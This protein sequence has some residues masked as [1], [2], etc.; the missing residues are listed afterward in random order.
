[1][2]NQEVIDA[3]LQ[4]KLDSWDWLKRSSEKAVDDA[5]A[6]MTPPP[7]FG[8]MKPW[9]H[10]KVCFLILQELKRFMLFLD[11]G[12]GKTGTTLQIIRYRKQCGEKPKCIVF[13]PYITAVNTWLDE[14]VKFAPDLEVV[15][16][17]GS[18]LQNRETLKGDGDVFVACY[19][20][21]VAMVTET[22][23]DKRKR[24]HKNKWKTSAQQ[25]RSYFEGFDMIVM[26]EI[27]KCRDVGSLTYRMCRAI[28]AQ[29]EWAIGLTGTPFGKDLADLWPQFYLVDFGE[30][31]G[32]TFGLFREAF[33]TNKAGY[34][35]GQ[36][37]KFRKKMMGQLKAFVRHRSIRYTLDEFIDMPELDPVKRFV[38]PPEGAEGYIEAAINSLNG[39]AK[40]RGKGTYQVIE[41][42][43]LQLRQL[44]SGF[45]TLRG[46]DNDRM[47]IKFVTSPKLD[48]LEE[49]IDSMPYDSKA[50]VF[51]HFKF[52]NGLISERLT[53]MKVKHARVWGGQR[54]PIGQ[55]KK[56]KDDPACRVLVLNDKSGS[57]S[58]NLQHANYMV[59]FEQ[60]DSPIDRQQAERR[61]WRPG[62]GKR[63]VMFDLLTRS[64][65]DSK[66][67]KSNKAGENLLHKLLGVAGKETQGELDLR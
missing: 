36:E 43:Y 39:A 9:L 19:Q 3:F 11:M 16:L 5:L 54:D 66:I 62:Q 67:Y 33:F 41:S 1:M 59:F 47:Q 28:S 22:V 58:L 4:R 32:E 40:D 12:G 52:T 21:A 26:D 56:F 64:T 37:Y 60:P 20:T 17:L 57:S 49:L 29:A 48:A 27:H 14:A 63:V 50:V 6:Q 44:S 18:R 42:N 2:I 23:R 24:K 34:F 10:Q 13:V 15:P 7:D 8:R 45:M 25:V 61:V 46:E 53:K 38:D 51:H 55:L 30:T 65:W 31:L 35:G